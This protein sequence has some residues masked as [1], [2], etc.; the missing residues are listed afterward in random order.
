MYF[1]SYSFNHVCIFIIG[2]I[3]F[4][5]W[6]GL[7]SMVLF[8]ISTVHSYVAPTLDKLIILSKPFTLNS[9]RALISNKVGY[10]CQTRKDGLVGLSGVR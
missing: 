7:T 1:I 8:L 5:S 10:S 6:L 2:G 3:N 4:S 9:V